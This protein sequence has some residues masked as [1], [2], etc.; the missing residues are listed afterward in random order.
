M[1]VILIDDRVDHDSLLVD[2]ESGVR[3]DGNPIVWSG[4]SVSAFLTW[5]RWIESGTSFKS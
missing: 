3:W 5:N 1:V 2:C 4:L